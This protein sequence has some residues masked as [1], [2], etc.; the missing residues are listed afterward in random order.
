MAVIK[1]TVSMRPKA[2]GDPNRAS[3]SGDAP[4]KKV[5]LGIHQIA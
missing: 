3:T 2:K 1:M 4:V 5:L